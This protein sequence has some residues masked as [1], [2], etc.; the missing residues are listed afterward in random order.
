MIAGLLAVTT[1]GGS[2]LRWYRGWNPF[3]DEGPFHGAAC[4]RIPTSL[5]NQA[6]KLYARFVLESYDAGPEDNAPIVLLRD[7]TQALWCL[8]AVADDNST[9]RR[10]RFESFRGFPFWRPRVRGLVQWSNGDEGTW[11][12]IDYDGKLREYWYSW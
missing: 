5:P 10:I 11:W 3:L 1:W 4:D 12:F 7:G 2:A 6:F 9:V 8:R